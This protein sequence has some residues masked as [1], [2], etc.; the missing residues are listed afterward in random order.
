MATSGGIR[1]WN[2]IHK[3]YVDG[4]L[5]AVM[6]KLSN[7]TRNLPNMPRGESIA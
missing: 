1:V 7:T 2:P 4:A 5:V 6:L 3:E